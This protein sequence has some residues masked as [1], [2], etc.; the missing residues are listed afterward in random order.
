[1]LSSLRNERDH[2]TLMAMIKKRV[3]LQDPIVIDYSSILTPYA[4]G[5]VSQQLVLRKKI[6]VIQDF[7]EECFVTSSQGLLK[8][9][10]ESC[11]CSFWNT[12]HLATLPTYVCCQGKKRPPFVC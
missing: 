4:L 11:Q 12:M 7:S 10:T 6:N 5:F 2:N 8:V 1:M 9:K 3:D